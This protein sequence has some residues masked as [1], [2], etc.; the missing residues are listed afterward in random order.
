VSKYLL[1]RQNDQMVV[2]QVTA[3]L[4]QTDYFAVDPGEVPNGQ[5]ITYSVRAEYV[6]DDNNAQTPV[7]LSGPSNPASVTG[8]NFAPVAVPD[9]LPPATVYSVKKNKTI[10][11]AAAGI[12]AN[13]TD[14]DSPAPPTTPY[15]LRAVL[16]STPPPSLGT[17]TLNANRLGGFTF[18]AGN[19]A[20][21]VTF[22]Y[23]VYNTCS[24]GTTPT[25]PAPPTAPPQCSGYSNLGT[26]TITVQ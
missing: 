14:V 2:A 17:V 3:V 24:L 9:G 19:V 6:D 8:V 23:R 15:S 1:V 5:T 26:V 7:P 21:Q 10:T 22:T 11:I 12:L 18:T 4:G 25:P 16:I 13:D 20:Q